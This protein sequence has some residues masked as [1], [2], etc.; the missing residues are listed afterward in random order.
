V[1]TLERLKMLI[2]RLAGHTV[3]V[4]GDVILDEYV[5]GQATRMSREAPVPVLEFESRRLIP[6]GAA[7]PAAN[8]NAL[9][10]TAVQVGV[11]G[12][13]TEATTLRQ[14]LQALGIE[15][16]SLVV[17]PARP[18]TLKTRLLAHM[19]L[20][21]PQQVARMDRLSREPISEDVERKLRGVIAGQ[22]PAVQA[23]LMSDYQIGLLTPSL[24]RT[25]CQ[26]ATEA[27][28]LLAADAQGGLDKYSGFGLVKCNA[29]EARAFLRRDLQGDDAFGRAAA[30]LCETLQLT[31]AM[32]ITRGAA[33]VTL[34]R[35]DG[36][37][38]HCPAPAVTDVYDTV[39]AGDTTVAVLTLAVLAGGSYEEAAMLANYASGLVVR[40]VGNYTPTPAELLAALADAETA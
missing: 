17:D 38:S 7:N 24:I 13:D 18:T 37:V 12:S 27:G 40:R 32:L 19:G 14:V 33:G 20:R 34:A 35:A 25:V 26:L 3:L 1:V 28:L 6:G 39:G 11:I 30:E 29:D 15:T 10:S 2:P 21:F 9:Q 8:I 16:G 22:L 36:V 5:L 31:G 23:V 4:L